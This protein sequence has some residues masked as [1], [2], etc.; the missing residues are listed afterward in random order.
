MKIVSYILD[1]KKR[2][3]HALLSG[4]QPECKNH[5]DIQLSTCRLYDK[6]RAKSSLE[7]P[8][9]FQSIHT[10]FSSFH[11]LGIT[12]VS[13]HM[14]PSE[15]ALQEGLIKFKSSKLNMDL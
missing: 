15:S 12:C 5:A 13:R 3:E 6:S 8:F 7:N 11:S 1:L 14:I 4:M 2:R 9:Q 10:I